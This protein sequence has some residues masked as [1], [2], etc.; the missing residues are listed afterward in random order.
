M[1]GKHSTC[2]YLTTVQ[3]GPSR[4]S[5]VSYYP[6]QDVPLSVLFPADSRSCMKP[7]LRLSQPAYSTWAGADRRER[8][9]SA[10]IGGRDGSGPV[11]VRARGG[12]K[13]VR[14]HRC[15]PRRSASGP[16]PAATTGLWLRRSSGRWQGGRP[17][18]RLEPIVWTLVARV[19][20][21][22]WIQRRASHLRSLLRKAASGATAAGGTPFSRVREPFRNGSSS[23]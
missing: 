5:S 12:A 4:L 20:R 6:L 19:P 14:G 22:E 7:V 23:A 16:V 11:R 21:W 3:A 18:R 15:A 8:T 17:W 10:T 1:V 13:P 2:S 9:K